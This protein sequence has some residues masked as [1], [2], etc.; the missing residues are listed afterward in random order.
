MLTNDT[1]VIFVNCNGLNEA[2]NTLINDKLFESIG[3]INLNEIVHLE[4]VKG[5]SKG[6]NTIFT[7]SEQ[8]IAAS[9]FVV[10]STTTNLHDILN[11]EF[12]LLDDKAELISF[13]K[14]EDKASILTFSI[15][16]IK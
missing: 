3:V 6:L 11:F 5:K 2:K 7:N 15:Q 14:T 4:K 8:P 16:V 13:P 9:H 12:S 10:G 1:N